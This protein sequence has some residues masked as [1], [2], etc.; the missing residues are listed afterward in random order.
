MFGWATYNIGVGVF[1]FNRFGD[2]TKSESLILNRACKIL[3]HETGH[4]FNL[5]H[6]IFNECLMCG[7][8]GLWELDLHPFNY[9]IVCFTKFHSVL[10]FDMLERCKRLSSVCGE[11]QNEFLPAKKYYDTLIEAVEGECAR[12][13]QL[14]ETK[15]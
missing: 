6:C 10:K 13:K 12:P 8:N 15:Q 5:R 1:S 3:C 9:C 7:L 4:M 11:F 14:E 2:D